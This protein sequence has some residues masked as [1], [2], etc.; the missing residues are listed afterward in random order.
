MSIHCSLVEASSRQ[1]L[2]KKKNC[3]RTRYVLA[4]LTCIALQS[5]LA[6][7][8]KASQQMGLL[9]PW[10][11]LCGCSPPRPWC[12]LHTWCRSIRPRN[13][14]KQFVGLGPSNLSDFFSPASI[15]TLS[16]VNTYNIHGEFHIPAPDRVKSVS[17]IPNAKSSGNCLPIAD[18]LG[19]QSSSVHCF[20]IKLY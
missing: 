2:Y 18:T 4:V 12:P 3:L 7:L 19:H 17:W 5:G 20:I 15:E 14:G 8:A 11:V 16:G 13:L 6:A 10:S 9:F 1:A